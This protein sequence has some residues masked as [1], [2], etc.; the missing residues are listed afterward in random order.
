MKLSPPSIIALSLTAIAALTTGLDTW[1]ILPSNPMV[2]LLIRWVALAGW[3]W[4]GYTKNSL[5]VWI[6]I[7][8]LLGAEI[9]YDAPAI[10]V[11]LRLFSQIFI[12]LIKA[13]VAPLIFGTLVVGIA[14]HS[15]LR[16]VGRMAWKSILYFE[17]I[18]TL[19]LVVGLAAINISKAGVGIPQMELGA[20]DIPAV[21]PQVW[22]EIVLH[23]FPENIAKS[24]A[25]GQEL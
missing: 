6:L 12:H 9:G 10:A 23:A 16:Q 21:K 5:T 4:F 20:S 1:Q 8:I 11:E 3:M 18:T 7:S 22:Q 13:V 14:G 19:A 25:D 24:I 17:V 15:D 2:L